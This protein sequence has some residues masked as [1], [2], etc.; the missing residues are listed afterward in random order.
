MSRDAAE[1]CQ[2]P[3]DLELVAN[4]GQMAPIRF[5]KND[6]QSASSS[7]IGDSSLKTFKLRLLHIWTRQSEPVDRYSGFVAADAGCMDDALKTFGSEGLQAHQQREALITSG[8][9]FLVE[10]RVLLFTGSP[11]LIRGQK[12]LKAS[13]GPLNAG[14][15]GE[16][17]IPDPSIILAKGI[18]PGTVETAT[19]LPAALTSGDIRV[20]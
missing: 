19:M 4:T 13:W 2:G 16:R 18:H 10:N 6:Y 11:R 5:G 1:C 20:P 8:C 15:E 12:V 7:P 17:H 14:E 9:I 3:I